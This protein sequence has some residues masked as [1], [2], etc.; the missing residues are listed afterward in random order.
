[1]RI[2]YVTTVGITMGFF[3]SLIRELLNHGDTV[4][5]ATN[6]LNGESIIPPCYREWGCK[7]YPISCSRSPLNKRNFTAVGEIKSI[8]SDGDYDIVHCHTPVAAT[9]TRIACKELRES[10]VKVIYTAHGFHFY[11][12]APLKNWL[13]FYPIEWLCAHWTDVLITINREDFELA[14]KH[15]YAKHV[16]YVPGVGI[17]V[18]KFSSV[19][20]DRAAKRKEIGVPEKVVLILSVGELNENKNHAVVIRALTKLNDRNV[21]YAIAGEGQL[22]SSLK[23]LAESLGLESQVHIL[24]YRKDVA[25]LYSVADIF[26]FPSKREGLPVAAMEAMA[27]GVPIVAA[28][29]RGTRDTFENGKTALIC[30]YDDVVGFAAAIQEMISDQE[31]RSAYTAANLLAVQRYDMSVIQPEMRNIYT[32]V[33]IS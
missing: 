14:K 4:D 21:H 29:N 17:D 22:K 24:G 12:G 8:V 33:F 2:L 28:D 25:E 30:S 16:E 26:V 9:C 3:K 10:G 27:A 23:Q 32:E 5:I 19:Q 18:K 31:K 7:V 13:L 15:M 1:M 6:E 20:V 11:K